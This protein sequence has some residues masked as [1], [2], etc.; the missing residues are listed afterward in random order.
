MG[1]LTV[2]ELMKELERLNP[3]AE[4]VI[5]IKQQNKAYGVIQLPIHRAYL[6]GQN[7]VG[8]WVSNSF[9][10]SI[11]IHLPENHFITKRVKK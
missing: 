6:D 4:I 7:N 5:N 1:N 9:G 10:G 11:T 2:R 3:D 8:G